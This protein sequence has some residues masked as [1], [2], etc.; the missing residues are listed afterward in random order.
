MKIRYSVSLHI[1]IVFSLILMASACSDDPAGNRD[2]PETPDFPTFEAAD[3]TS[4][5]LQIS[6]TPADT[7]QNQT[8]FADARPFMDQ[9]MIFFTSLS[10]NRVL[11]ELA[12]ETEAEFEDD[13]FIWTVD[14]NSFSEIF[15]TSFNYNVIADLSGDQVEWRV[16]SDL[17]GLLPP[18]LITNDAAAQKIEWIRGF[19]SDDGATGEWNIF[20]PFAGTAA[21]TGSGFFNLFG[22]SLN[23]FL[24]QRSERLSDFLE[25]DSFDENL[26]TLFED[27]RFAWEK[28]SD[29]EKSITFTAVNAVDGSEITWMFERIGTTL[30]FELQNTVGEGNN[31]IIV[32]NLESGEG[33]IEKNGDRKCWDENRENTECL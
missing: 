21:F 11:F 22:S 33:F 24:D 28:I 32:L 3:L 10:G 30:R 14:V 13:S 9:T 17:S 18:E 19:S 29:M 8:A 20:G 25:D 15:G 23:D 1:L 26:F 27:A 5:S 31:I 2:I 6:G 7:T 16:E 4:E 12:A